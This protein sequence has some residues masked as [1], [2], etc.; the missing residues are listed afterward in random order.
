MIRLVLVDDQ[1]LIRAGIATLLGLTGDIQVVGEAADGEAA[2]NVITDMQPDVVLLDVRLPKF[3]GIDVLQ[4]LSD[5]GRLPPTILLTTFDDDDALKRGM[6]AG[7]KGFLLKDI[8]LE[9]LSEAIREVAA[10]KSL[11]LPCMTQQVH[12][13]VA[14]HADMNG[15]T[16]EV[17]TALTRRETEILRLLAAG[18]SNRE[19]AAAIGNQEGTIKNH[20]SNILAK[21]GVRDRSRAVLRAIQLGYL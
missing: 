2:I 16:T 18:M 21:L 8:S 3:S 9:K 19:I 6:E 12:D 14:D 5:Q 1:A 4:A 13:W 7:A 20:V 11:F 17:S 10:G 15:S